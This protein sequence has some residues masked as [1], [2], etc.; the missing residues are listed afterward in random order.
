MMA[1]SR[2]DSMEIGHE[3][4]VFSAIEL[5]KLRAVGIALQQK[6]GAANELYR[7]A[8]FESADHWLF[9]LS[10]IGELV[11]PEDT[12][13][14]PRV[15][16]MPDPLDEEGDSLQERVLCLSVAQL[17]QEGESTSE[18]DLYTFHFDLAH[19]L[20]Q[21][22]NLGIVDTSSFTDSETK[23]EDVIHLYREALASAEPITDPNEIELIGTMISNLWPRPATVGDKLRQIFGS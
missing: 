6:I 21:I 1:D 20:K 8:G 7:Y 22:K 11:I 16:I 12:L 10:P 18:E 4:H 14:T 17:N 13:D 19:S 3:G 15:A 9:D 23:A 5:Q 2:E